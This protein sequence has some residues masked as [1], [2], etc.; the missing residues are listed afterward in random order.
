MAKTSSI[1]VAGYGLSMG[2]RCTACLSARR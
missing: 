2:L 1:K